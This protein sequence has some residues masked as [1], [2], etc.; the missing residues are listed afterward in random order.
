MYNRKKT[1]ACVGSG[2]I[3]QGWATLF[4]AA[5]YEVMMQDVVATNLKN[6]VERVHLNLKQ[7]ED[8]GRLQGQSVDEAHRLIRTTHSIE[9]AVSL[10]DYVLEA[11]PDNYRAK[12]KR[13]PTNGR[14]C[15][16]R[17]DSGQQ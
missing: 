6:A 8:N 9:K 7:L 13:V 5:G 12:K 11:V 10:S 14:T 1:V 15:S 16:G 17:F 3:G 4:A 2:L